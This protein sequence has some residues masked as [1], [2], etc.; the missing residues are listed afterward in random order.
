MLEGAS[1]VSISTQSD[2]VVIHLE[3]P[4]ID[5][6]VTFWNTVVYPRYVT[7]GEQ[8]TIVKE[9]T[10]DLNLLSSVANVLTTL[11]KP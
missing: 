1:P 5:A 11:G 6:F 9:L 8:V 7:P 4:S 2:K 3:F 10:T